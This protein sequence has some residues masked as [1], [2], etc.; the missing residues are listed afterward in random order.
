MTNTNMQV[1][2]QSSPLTLTQDD[3]HR[4]LNDTSSDT[5]I[6][7]TDRIAGAYGKDVLQGNEI[8]IAEQ[9][10]RLLLRDTELRVRISLAE[11]V[12]KSETIPRDIV[13]S[14]AKDVEEVSLPVLEYSQVLSEDD[15]LE[16]IE[17]S[18]EV[19]KQLA[20]SKR[21]HVPARV[22]DSLLDK[23][24][25]EVAEALAENHG[26]ELT[27]AGVD[28]IIQSHKGSNAIMGA[29]SERANLPSAAVNKLVNVVSSSLAEKLKNKYQVSG[30]AIDR[31]VDKTREKETLDLIK[32]THNKEAVIKLV[33][34]T[35]IY[36]RLTPSLILGALC[37]GNVA[38]FEAS[39]AAL[40]DVPVDNAHTLINDKGELG[41]RA[42]Y[43]KS[44][45]P[46][47][48]FQAVNLLVKIVHQLLDEGQQPA[49][50]QF[51][52]RVV[53]RILEQSESGEVDNVSYIIALV[54]KAARL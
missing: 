30:Q 31:E 36:N 51:A 15:L 19:S 10:F 20:I 9:V 17:A 26:A 12:K 23:G 43:N 53:E 54:R 37:V 21:K 32:R 18:K 49:T 29:L 8:M 41:F 52:N 44:G 47:G 5:R 34:Q 38:F 25:G 1:G 14:L 22:T 2:A 27:E 16:L 13:K 46:D 28:K 50:G 11:H 33:G 7:M 6:D 42:I 48:M 24:N 39:L 3:V 45:L 40:S 4:L 35:R